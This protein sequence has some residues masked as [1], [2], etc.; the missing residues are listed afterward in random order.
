[1][2]DLADTV[3]TELFPIKKNRGRP[4][5]GKAKTAAERQSAYRKN[6]L[7]A[8]KRTP[9]GQKNL[10]VWID[11][12]CKCDLDKLA[13]HYEISSSEMIERLV[14]DAHAKH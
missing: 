3:T 9:N 12:G 7:K 11:A 10:N 1:M 13:R 14:A 8:S 6:K 2:K 4:T 5:T